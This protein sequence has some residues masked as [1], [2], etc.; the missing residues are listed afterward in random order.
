[1]SD[2]AHKM[3]TAFDVDP[4]PTTILSLS[5]DTT[6]LIL[7]HAGFASLS[8]LL[9]GA[10][11]SLAPDTSQNARAVE[12]VG[13]TDSIVYILYRRLEQIRLRGV[14]ACGSREAKGGP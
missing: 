2:A 13:E 9:S 7:S 5:D 12:R 10:G 6:M 11:G 8:S 1:M 4:D 14:H 3:P